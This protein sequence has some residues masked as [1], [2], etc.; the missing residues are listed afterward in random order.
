MLTRTPRNL[1][2]DW[3]KNMMILYISDHSTF[4][5]LTPSSPTPSSP[6]SPFHYQWNF[7]FHWNVASRHRSLGFSP[8]GGYIA[9]HIHAFIW[10]TE[11]HEL[12]AYFR[13]QEFTAW[14]LNT[15]EGFNPA[16]YTVPTPVFFH[17]YSQP[18]EDMDG[19]QNPG[20]GIGK[21]A[22]WL[23]CPSYD[24]ATIIHAVIKWAL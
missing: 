12:V 17:P 10:S 21:D 6:T 20:Q 15:G 4:Q 13:V 9:D 23:K 3:H 8:Q 19:V 11:S 7:N 24:S 16:L 14:M 18:K 22:S 1:E 5:S 2:D